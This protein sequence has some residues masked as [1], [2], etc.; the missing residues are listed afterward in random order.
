MAGVAQRT[1]YTLRQEVDQNC[2]G[3]HS[4][5]FDGRTHGEIF[6]SC[7][8]WYGQYW[9]SSLQQSVSQLITSVATII[10]VMVMMLSISWPDDYHCL[11][12]LAIKCNCG[13]WH[14]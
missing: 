14:C 6:K 3:Y 2:R 9:F 13:S 7:S 12:N 4:K 8:Q 1:I 5:F 10:G 11:T